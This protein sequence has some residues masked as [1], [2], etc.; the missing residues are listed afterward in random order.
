MALVFYSVSKYPVR[1]FCDGRYPVRQGR[2]QTVQRSTRRGPS[3]GLRVRGLR[4]QR[5][6]TIRL[7]GRR[8][9]YLADR[10]IRVPPIAWLEGLGVESRFRQKVPEFLRRVYPEPTRILVKCGTSVLPVR[11][12]GA[13]KKTVCVEH[14]GL[15]D[16]MPH[17]VKVPIENS[18]SSA[19]ID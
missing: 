14:T 2:Y 12:K 3:Y 9:S 13:S 1:H 15:P 10:Q 8:L 18:H 11:L 19:E 6:Y 4:S 17:Y 7:M 5:I 16:R